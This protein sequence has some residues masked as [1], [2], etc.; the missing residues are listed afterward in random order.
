VEWIRGAVARYQEPLLRFAVRLTR[1]RE[2]A[3]DV[4]QDTFLKLCDQPRGAVEGH[5]ARWL[6]TVCRNRAR[7]VARKEGRM[8]LLDGGQLEAWESREPAPDVVVEKDEESRELSR[9]LATLPERQ[10]EV[11]RLRFRN[12]LSYAEIAEALELSV[13]HVGVLIAQLDATARTLREVLRHEESPKLT[14][15]QR[16]RIDARSRPVAAGRALWVG[17]GLAAAALLALAVWLPLGPETDSQVAPSGPVVVRP[18]RVPLGSRPLPLA[19][20]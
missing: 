16:R 6:F 7:D 4:V 12:D 14:E 18:E 20:S 3:R 5:L 9:L 1:D 19:P 11:L 15:T 13:S 10:Q 17:G 2:R 8:S